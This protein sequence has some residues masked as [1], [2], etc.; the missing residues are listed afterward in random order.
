MVKQKKAVDMK[1]SE[2]IDEL[3]EEPEDERWGELDSEL[4]K[5][6]PFKYFQEQIDEITE[7]L[8]KLDLN[9]SKHSHMDGKLV[10]DI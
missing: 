10:R 7:K 5:R 9:F 1:T 3:G 8:D 2:L 4:D 6:P